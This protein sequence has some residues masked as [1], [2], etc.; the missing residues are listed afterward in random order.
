MESRLDWDPRRDVLDDLI[1]DRFAVRRHDL[2]MDHGDTAT[3]G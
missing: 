1:D 2:D 3:S